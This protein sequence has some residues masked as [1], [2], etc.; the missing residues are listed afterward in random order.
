MLEGVNANKDIRRIIMDS[1]LTV[2]L[3]K[4]RPCFCVNTGM[5][6]M[7]FGLME[8]NVMMAIMIQEMVATIIK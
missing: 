2:N 3:N 8:S 6:R 4:A 7:V 5:P 1:V